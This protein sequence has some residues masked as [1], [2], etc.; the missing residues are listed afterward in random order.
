MSAEQRFLPKPFRVPAGPA[1]R[2]VIL[3]VPPV[4]GLDVVGPLDV[5]DAANRW[6]ERPAYTLELV[7]GGKS[8]R[9]ACGSGL[10]LAAK[11]RYSELHGEIDTLIVAG[12]SG[13][14]EAATPELVR[15]LARQAPR[16]RR[17]GSVCT[18]AYLLGAAGLLDGR[19]VTTHWAWARQLASLYPEAHVD[20]EPIWLRDEHLYSSAGVTAGIDLCLSL[21]KDDL[22]PEAALTIARYL[23]LYLHRPGGQGQ[24]SVPLSAQHTEAPR[25]AALVP[26]MLA[27]LRGDLSVPRLAQKAGMSPRNFAR[28]FER[29]FSRG[30]GAYVRELRL[31]AARRSLESSERSL[32]EV[33]DACGFNS[34][35]VMGRAFRDRLGVT[36]GGYRERF[37]RG[38]RA[39]SPGRSRVA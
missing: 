12:G 33:A 23:V 4:Q 21:V 6:A 9:V 3:G 27:N 26:F 19:T 10:E 28:A 24:F 11:H 13:A 29:E 34:A 18:G 15:W 7:S 1:K 5:F 30:P 8:R 2:V 20:P 36:P 37:K 31:E 35:E 17:Y 14:R 25:L 32:E 16:A 38:R 39:R 22:G